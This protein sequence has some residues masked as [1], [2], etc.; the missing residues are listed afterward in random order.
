MGQHGGSNPGIGNIV[1]GQ[2]MVL[3]QAFE[4]KPFTSQSRHL[5]F[6]GIQHGAQKR[7][8]GFG[9]RRLNK[10]LWL[11]DQTQKTP[12]QPSEKSPMDGL[13]HNHRVPYPAR[14]KR[15]RAV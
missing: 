1:A 12:P 9:R 11:G 14:S 6:G 7:Q 13:F 5:H 10:H 2:P 15:P 8:R 4:H 3:A